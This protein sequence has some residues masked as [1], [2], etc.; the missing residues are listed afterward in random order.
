MKK[1]EMT[2][3]EIQQMCAML[4]EADRSV[5]QQEKSLA[6]AKEYSRNLREESIPMAM[7]ELSIESI[8]LTSG[9]KFSISLEV[10]ASIPAAN[11]TAALDWLEQHDFGG[12]IKTELTSTFGKGELERAQAAQDLLDQFGYTTEL[13]R[14]VHTQTLKAFLKEQLAKAGNNVPLDLFGARPTWSTK[15]KKPKEK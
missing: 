4:L 1:S 15:I 12:L 13:T 6:A 8:T 14:N 7:Q 9:E 2:L 5:E 3:Q 10:Y 11:K